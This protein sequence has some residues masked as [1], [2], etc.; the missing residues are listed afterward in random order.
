[1]A[2]IYHKG[3]AEYKAG[4]LFNGG[5]QREYKAEEPYGAVRALDPVSGAMKWEYRLH[6]PSHAGLMSTAG[7]LVFGS[8]GSDFF[9]LDAK[10]GKL[11]WN[12][13][14]GGGIIANPVTYMYGGKQFVL[15]P[16]GHS[17]FAF[18]LD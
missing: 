17:L 10:E 9:A 2:G 16:A 11:L 6:S 5:G 15:I 8:N 7:G 12:F 3:N 1:M 4:A 13:E 18:S 14:T